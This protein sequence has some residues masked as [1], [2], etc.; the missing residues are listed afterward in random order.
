MIKQEIMNENGTKINARLDKKFICQAILNKE[1]YT[2]I[3]ITRKYATRFYNQFEIDIEMTCSKVPKIKSFI[4]VTSVR[5][6]INIINAV[7]KQLEFNEINKRSTNLSVISSIENIQKNLQNIMEKEDTNGTHLFFPHNWNTIIT[8]STN[9][10]N[11]KT[12]L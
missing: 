6:M 10:D 9:L 11:P 7:C 4:I 12:N 8:Y 3:N 2:H 1:F 5:E